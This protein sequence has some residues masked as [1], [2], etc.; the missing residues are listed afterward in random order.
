[1]AVAQTEGGTV[2]HPFEPRLGPV[3][4][5]GS[6]STVHEW[7]ADSSAHCGAPSPAVVKVP[8]DATPEGWIRYEAMYTATIHAAG[9]PV[10]EVLELVTVEGRTASVFERIGGR[11]MWA[12]VLADPDRAELIGQDLAALHAALFL[13]TPPVSLPAQ[14]D[15][16]RC[17]VRA[18][19]GLLCTKTAD[20]VGRIPPRTAV[21]PRL[22]HGDL[23]PCN[24]LL[25]PLGPVVIDWFDVSRGDPLGDVARTSLLLGCG[26]ADSVAHL[27]GGSA[28]VLRRVHDAYLRAM[29]AHLGVGEADVE[30]WREIEAVAQLAE[31]LDPVA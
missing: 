26:N 30:P 11:T 14:H 9:A 24:V 6:R 8:R 15:R 18:A 16:L 29:C 28:G 27:E 7:L 20:L 1:M 21:V 4:A 22:C 17:K 5:T 31:R 13:I 19:A 3:V 23:H 2:T 10:P 25:G 12:E